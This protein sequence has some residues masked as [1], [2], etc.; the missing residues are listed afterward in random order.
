MLFQLWFQLQLSVSSEYHYE[1]FISDLDSPWP[2]RPFGLSARRR[3]VA[4][5]SITHRLVQLLGKGV[6]TRTKIAGPKWEA[7]KLLRNG[8]S[9]PEE[10]DATTHLVNLRKSCT[11]QWL[12]ATVHKNSYLADWLFVSNNLHILNK[13]TRVYVHYMHMHIFTYVD[14]YVYIYTYIHIYDKYVH[15]S[16]VCNVL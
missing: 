5:A 11:M 13:F 10:M 7:K 14:E 3:I 6:L 2:K 8:W 15:T 4:H 16:Y 1:E 9:M 12:T